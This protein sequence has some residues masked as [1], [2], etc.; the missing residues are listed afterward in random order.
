[1][2]EAF[3]ILKLSQLVPKLRTIARFELNTPRIYLK[4]IGPLKKNL[5]N[6]TKKAISRE[7]SVKDFVMRLTLVIKMG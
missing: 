7:M 2:T 3:E 1:M 5:Y 6:H 4:I